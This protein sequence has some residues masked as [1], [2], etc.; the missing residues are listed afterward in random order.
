[1]KKLYT[2]R[3]NI[4]NAILKLQILYYIMIKR[5]LR[6]LWIANRLSLHGFP[7]LDSSKTVLR[8][9]LCFS[10]ERSDVGTGSTA[11]L[12]INC[13]NI[14]N[15]INKHKLC[16]HNSKE[17]TPPMSECGIAALYP[18]KKYNFYKNLIHHN[19]QQSCLEIL[20]SCHFFEIENISIIIFLLKRDIVGA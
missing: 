19:W 20:S 13:L 6:L 4:S 11:A 3:R 14:L 8:P 9:S 12:L 1:M 7:S 18:N 16:H 15:L 2:I 10:L 5:R 17:T